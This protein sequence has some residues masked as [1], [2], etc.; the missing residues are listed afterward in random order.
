[1]SDV[2]TFQPERRTGQIFQFGTLIL[3]IGAEIGCLSAATSA[4]GPVALWFYLA[5]LFMAPG[6]PL[7]AYRIYAL[8][9]ASYSLEREAIH[10]RWGL[11]VEDI[12]MTQVLWVR[13]VSDLSIPVR[14]PLFSWNGSILGSRRQAGLGE[15]EFFASGRSGLVLIATPARSYVI[16]PAHPEAFIRTFQ[17]LTELGSLAPARSRSVYPAMM[18]RRIWEVSPARTLLVISL[19]LSLALVVAVSLAIPTRAQVSLGFRA[20]GLPRDPVPAAQLLLL[21]VLNILIVL[22]DF[23]VGLFFFRRAES[24]SLAYLLWLGSATT[25][26][27]FLLGAFFILRIS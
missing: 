23:V 1:V 14:P 10:L 18:L 7:L 16:S 12:P 15:V 22:F 4:A 20:N 27:L 26:L 6:I 8:R 11:R 9:T 13:L 3:L 2:Y 17:R 5:S 25:P 19:V 24:E 21:P